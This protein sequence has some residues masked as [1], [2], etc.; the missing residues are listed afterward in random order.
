MANLAATEVTVLAAWS[1]GSTT[2]K[3]RTV[4]RCRLENTSAGITAGGNTNLMPVVAFGLTVIEE[5]SSLLVYTTSG[6]ASVSIYDTAPDY[7][8]A[9]INAKVFGAQ[10]VADAAITTAQRGIITVKGY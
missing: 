5:C 8:G 7:T 10:G 6:G 4:K 2:G 9:K 3:R 1:E